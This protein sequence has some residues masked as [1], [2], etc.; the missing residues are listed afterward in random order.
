LREFYPFGGELQF[1]AADATNHYKFTGKERDAETNLD[2]FG[3]RYYSSTLGRWVSADW[4]AIPA[5]VPYADFADPQS[6]NLYTYVRNLPTTKVDPEGHHPVLEEVVEVAAKAA[7]NPGTM[8]AAVSATAAAA[9]GATGG[10]GGWFGA[11]LKGVTEVGLVITYLA[12]PNSGPQCGNACDLT[13][14]TNKGG[15]QL[16]QARGEGEEVSQSDIAKERARTNGGIATGRNHEVDFGN[17]LKRDLQPGQKNSVV[18]E[19]TGSRSGDRAAANNA[20]GF[21]ST[22]NGYTWHHAADYNANTNTGTMQLVKFDP[23]KRYHHGGVRQYEQAT[24]K[25]YKP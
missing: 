17:D 8:A 11:F 18:I 1:S 5:P 3:A 13:P 21:E 20:A 7:S 4:S 19:Y 9:E 22:P 16:G 25:K 14:I 2:Y 10:G 12:S 24:G 23:H 6:L 15:L